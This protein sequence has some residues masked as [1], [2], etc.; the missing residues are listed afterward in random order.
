MKSIQLIIIPLL[1]ILISSCADKGNYNQTETKISSR[2]DGGYSLKIDGYTQHMQPVTAEGFFPKQSMH[3]EIE[4][5]GPG[6]D[7]TYR[8]QPGYYYSFPND[9]KS[10]KEHWD[11]GYAWVDLKR[12]YIYLNFYWIDSPNSVNKSRVN[13][14]YKI[15]K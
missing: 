10:D 11:F 8:N 6:K 2:T 7:L 13:G 1:A 15:E 3:Y 4:L 9:I 5:L 14:R 12:E